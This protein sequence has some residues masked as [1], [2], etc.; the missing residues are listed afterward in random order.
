MEALNFPSYQFKIRNSNKTELQI[1]D[2]VRKKYVKL[3][4]EEWVR[5]HVVRQL[6]DLNYPKGLIQ[7]E[8][9]IRVFKTKKRFDILVND[10]SARPLLLVECKAANVKLDQKTFN[11]IAR[12]NSEICAPYL[13][14]SN[15]INHYFAE[16]SDQQY[17]FKDHLPN[18]LDLQIASEL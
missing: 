13:F 16:Y 3:T 1:L 12:Y 17:T 9:E 7:I 10:T 2:D 6:I 11:Q 18:Y 4:P 5:Q 15:G 8:G 14:I